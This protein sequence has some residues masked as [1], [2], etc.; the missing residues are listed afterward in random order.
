[1]NLVSMFINEGPSPR[2]SE[3]LRREEKVLVSY[4]IK[5]LGKRSLKYW[6]NRY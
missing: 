6:P 2:D 4:S 5:M 1:M 3:R